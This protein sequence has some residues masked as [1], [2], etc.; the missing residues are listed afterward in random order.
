MVW[1]LIQK[2][3]DEVVTVYA[4]HPD[5]RVVVLDEDAF[6]DLK[7]VRLGQDEY[8]ATLQRIDVDHDPKRVEDAF[9]QADD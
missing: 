1:L 9:L 7:R 8:L 2:S 6:E 4:S 3:G 5:V